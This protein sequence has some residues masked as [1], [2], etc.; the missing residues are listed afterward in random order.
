MTALE[1]PAVRLVNVL[2]TVISSC[3]LSLAAAES[4]LVA[5]QLCLQ[6]LQVPEALQVVQ[7]QH[8]TA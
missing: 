6:V 8:L 5:V 3:N 2:R 1:L 7:P 4:P